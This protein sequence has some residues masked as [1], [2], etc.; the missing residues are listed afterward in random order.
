MNKIKFVKNINEG[1]FEMQMEGS[2]DIW[3]ACVNLTSKD[4]AV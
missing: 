2:T 3:M 4:D 1:K